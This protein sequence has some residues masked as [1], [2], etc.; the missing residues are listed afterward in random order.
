MNK[1][2]YIFQLCCYHGFKR[3]ELKDKTLKELKNIYGGI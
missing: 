3:N 2:D 1:S